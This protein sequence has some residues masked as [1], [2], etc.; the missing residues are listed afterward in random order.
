MCGLCGL[1]GGILSWDLRINSILGVGRSLGVAWLVAVVGLALMGCAPRGVRLY[2]YTASRFQRGAYRLY[3]LPQDVLVV[4]FTLRRSVYTP[5]PYAEYA[6]QFLGV[7]PPTMQGQTTWAIVSATISRQREPDRQQPFLAKGLS[8]TLPA[9][10]LALP[11]GSL[12][13][14][15]WEQMARPTPNGH[16]PS[17]PAP[18]FLD[19]AVSP[20]VQ[21]KKSTYYQT[22]AK[23]SSFVTV[24]VQRT[25]MVQ[26]GLQQQAQAVAATIFDLRARRL[27]LLRGDVEVTGGH[28]QLESM[29]RGI[30]RME[31]QYLSL[32][33]GLYQTDTLCQQVRY[34]PTVESSYD[35]LCRFSPTEGLRMTHD[36]AAL[37]VLITLEPLESMPVPDTVRLHNLRGAYYYRVPRLVKVSLRVQHTLLAEF[38]T[39]VAQL[40]SL[41]IFPLGLGAQ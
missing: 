35:M 41:A 25:V 31:Q 7:E 26:E 13:P 9:E 12:M 15:T 14:A 10:F 19:R 38:V 3:Y 11:E 5:G 21:T 30:D 33:M 4:D 34:T 39:P 36:A 23:D 37:P 40:G 17:E 27:D 24:P 18:R 20:F 32:F 2:P 28:Q 29:L 6:S 22:V 8:A 1:F 16:L